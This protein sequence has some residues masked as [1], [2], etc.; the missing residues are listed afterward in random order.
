MVGGYVYR[1]NNVNL[2]GLLGT[3]LFADFG[4]GTVW[5]IDPSA[6]NV[7]ASLQV[8]LNTGRQISSFGEDNLG[9]LYVL[10]WSDGQI[11]K[12]DPASISNFPMLLSQTG[13]VDPTNPE[14]TDSSMIPYRIN[15]EFWSDGAVKNR[16]FALQDATEITIE[17]DGDWTF[18]IGGVLLK[19]FHLNSQLVETRLLVHHADDS[20]GGYSY[21]WNDSGT[22]ATLRLNGKS[23]NIDGQ[24]YIYP[25]SSQCAACHTNAAGNT[26]GPQTAQMNR[27][28]NYPAN[29][30]AVGNQ[31]ATLD[32]IGM[33]V[34]SPGDP[35]ILP[36]LDD[37]HNTLANEDNRVRAYWH[38]NCGQCHRPGHIIQNVDIDFRFDTDF[39]DM[40][41]CNR[42]PGAGDLGV[43]GAQRLTP[44]SAHES[45]V[46]LRMSRRDT[47]TMP[48]LGST[49]IDDKSADLLEDWI[50]G[51]AGCP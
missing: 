27:K 45:L 25:S 29:G 17:A 34:S 50:D 11:F 19:H 9:E 21:E 22:D 6:S 51:L 31:I 2:A 28:Q 18:P 23:K 49:V 47:D 20:W 15:A 43:S 39:N 1:G 10:S 30:N 5:G 26:L 13:C 36:K 46:Y 35:T 8:L 44:G 38:S 3:Y 48:P 14:V 42:A 37:P 32:N 40:N 41:I 24:E 7:S 33:F 4:F 16:W 12:I